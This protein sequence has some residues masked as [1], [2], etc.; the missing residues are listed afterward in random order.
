M[1]GIRHPDIKPE[2]VMRVIEYPYDQWEEITRSGDLRTVIVGRVAQSNQWIKVV[3]S[4]IG[5]SRELITAYQDR[6]LQK[7]YGGRPWRNQQ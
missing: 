3:F 4:G 1:S 2:W 5:D 7:R 6:R